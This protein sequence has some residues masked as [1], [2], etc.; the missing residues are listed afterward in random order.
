MLPVWRVSGVRLFL[1]GSVEA[2]QKLFNGI[3][4]LTHAKT[5]VDRSMAAVVSSSLPNLYHPL[6]LPLTDQ[7]NTM[8]E[9]KSR[10]SALDDMTFA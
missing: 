1:Q 6:R 4:F 9:K 3:L 5:R 7:E 2:E 8:D 10:S